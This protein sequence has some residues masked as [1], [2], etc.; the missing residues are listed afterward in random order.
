MFYKFR[1]IKKRELLLDKKHLIGLIDN[2]LTSNKFFF[3]SFD[4]VYAIL[5]SITELLK[6]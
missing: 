4:A 2:N 5:H 1:T 3:C 6:I